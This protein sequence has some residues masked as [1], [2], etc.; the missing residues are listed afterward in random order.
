MYNS[1]TVSFLLTLSTDDLNASMLGVV[2]W[3]EGLPTKG[4][5]KMHS[6][7]KPLIVL[8]TGEL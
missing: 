1:R 3:S 5:E 6:V 8:V 2:S 7:A 4:L